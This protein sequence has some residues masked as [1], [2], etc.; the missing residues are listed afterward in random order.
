M[1]NT[2][3]VRCVV[4][5]AVQASSGTCMCRAPRQRT[6]KPHLHGHAHAATWAHLQADQ[7]I[8]TACFAIGQPA[9][10]NRCYG[11]I[12]GVR[13]ALNQNVLRVAE[14]GRPVFRAAA[15]YSVPL[16]VGQQCCC[17]AGL[18]GLAAVAF[19]ARNA[20][21]LT[22]GICQPAPGCI[23]RAGAQGQAQEQQSPRGHA[24]GLCCFET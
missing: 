24:W 17:D 21:L 19:S 1:A 6:S 10:G 22:G 5:I 8:P 11:R 12:H 20:V 7:F 23:T 4:R 16:G 13:A 14:P 3:H 2:M 15:Q 18:G 9:L